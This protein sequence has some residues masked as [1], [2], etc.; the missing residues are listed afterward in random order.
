MREKLPDSVTVLQCRFCQRLRVRNEYIFFS[1]SSLAEAVKKELH[2]DCAVKVKSF[3][4]GTASLKFNCGV[5]HASI[6]F[7]KEMRVKINYKTCQQCYR[8]SSGYY[9]ALIQLRGEREKIDRI[10]KNLTYFINKNGAF[11]SKLEEMDSGYDIYVSDKL[12]TN[13]FFSLHRL[14]PK[15]SFK[16]Y[17]LRRGNRVYRNIY[18]LRV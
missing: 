5:D 4:K 8:M 7:E 15:K 2:S 11:V 3:D 1:D 18:A 13:Q 17:G 10:V 12:L 16:L 14:K 9:E 6:K